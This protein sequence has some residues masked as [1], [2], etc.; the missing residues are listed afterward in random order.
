MF[1]RGCTQFGYNQKTWREC[2]N[3]PIGNDNEI[4]F[5]HFFLWFIMKRIA[6]LKEN[7]PAS[8]RWL[9]ISLGIDYGSVPWRF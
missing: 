4:S 1:P 2:D 6:F 5:F 7:L 9:S 3:L 8:D